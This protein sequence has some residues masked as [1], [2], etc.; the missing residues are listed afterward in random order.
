[1]PKSLLLEKLCLS[2]V[3]MALS[4]SAMSTTSFR[5]CLI[6]FAF[7]FMALSLS[8]MVS[9]HYDRY[10][11]CCPKDEGTPRVIEGLRMTFSAAIGCVCRYMLRSHVLIVFCT[12]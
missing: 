8:L 9:Q 4:T 10:S 3:A 12:R 1:M 7:S 2:L 11:E 5:E 6:D